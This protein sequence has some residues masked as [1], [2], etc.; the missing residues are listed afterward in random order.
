M[1]TDNELIAEFM[2][3]PKVVGGYEK[4]D[5]FEIY[6]LEEFQFHNSWDWLIPVI[7]KINSIRTGKFLSKGSILKVDIS[8][9]L[10]VCD[11]AKTYKAVVEFIKWYDQQ[12]HKP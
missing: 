5:A 6:A 8:E 3:M 11:I 12:T 10:Q 1:K 2:Q 7:Q 9:P 4:W